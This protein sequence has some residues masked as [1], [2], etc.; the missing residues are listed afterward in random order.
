MTDS[1]ETFTSRRL[2]AEKVELRHFEELCR[3]HRDVAVMKTLSADGRPIHDDV[4][5]TM[6]AGAIAH[7]ELHG[8]GFWIF[9]ERET[10]VFVGRGGL[11][12]YRID[13]TDVLGLAYAVVSTQFGRGYATEMAEGSL[14]IG[15]DRLGVPEVESWTLPSNVAS[16]R[17]MQKLGFRYERIFEFAGLTHWFYRLSAAEWR[18]RAGSTPAVS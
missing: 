1:I 18:E 16:Q 5:R 14:A 2:I 6:L 9:R 7:W 12:V 10:G 15:F 17:V 3:L 4:T 11:K 8:F 13:E